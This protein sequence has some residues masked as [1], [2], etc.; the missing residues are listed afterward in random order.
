MHIKEFQVERGVVWASKT[1][2]VQSRRLPSRFIRTGYSN[3]SG[4]LVTGIKGFIRCI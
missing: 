3:G 4:A 2:V 1:L